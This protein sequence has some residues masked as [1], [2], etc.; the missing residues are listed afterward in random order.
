MHGAPPALRA[1][2]PTQAGR[3][4]AA[5]RAL[6]VPSP[7]E[8]EGGAQRRDRGQAD[9]CSIAATLPR[10]SDRR[11]S[12]ARRL[13]RSAGRPR[14]PSPGR[15]RHR[16]AAAAARGGRAH[17]RSRRAPAR[18]RFRRRPLPPP[19]PARVPPVRAAALRLR[20]AGSRRWPSSGCCRCAC[21]PRPAAASA[22]ARRC[23]WR[24]C[25]GRSRTAISASARRRQ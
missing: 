4:K 23:R 10:R 21:W 18:G 17:R 3:G 7:F 25:G 12:R 16:P 20:C 24:R 2:S 11:L 6:D 19:R 15:R 5:H 22:V 14:S 9:R 13:R 8:G 1:P